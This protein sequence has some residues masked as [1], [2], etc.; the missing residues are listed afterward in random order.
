LATWDHDRRER[1]HA[2][3]AMRV[4]LAGTATVAELDELARARLVE[5]LAGRALF[6]QRPWTADIDAQSSLRI[7]EALAGTRGVLLSHCHLGPYPRLDRARPFH[8]QVTYLVPGP[9][10]FE[11]PGY[12]RW[13]RRLAR[14]RRATKS[15]PV[16]ASGSFRI[17]QSLLERGEAVFIAFDQP[18]PKETTFLGKRAMMAE[19]TAQLAVRADALVV[20]VRARRRGHRVH[21][22]AAE[23]IDPRELGGVDEVHEALV[24]VHE[25]WVLETPAEMEDPRETGW[26]DG[27]TS[28]AWDASVG[29]GPSQNGA[30]ED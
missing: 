17:V 24:A 25:Q 11:Q 30:P 10:Y 4:V 2:I 19:G 22:D 21:V 14:W 23:P 13:G 20:P 7:A 18:G 5:Q 6:W 12:G 15:R 1:E 26:G 28:Q 3:R 16:Q 8:G 29:G 9:W 27:A